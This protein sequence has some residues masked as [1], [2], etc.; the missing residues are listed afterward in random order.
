MVDHPRVHPEMRLDFG[1]GMHQVVDGR[2]SNPAAPI[3]SPC[4]SPRSTEENPSLRKRFG[5]CDKVYVE[6]P[7]GLNERFKC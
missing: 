1:Q 5:A 7:S 6:H 3:L 4:T 2:T